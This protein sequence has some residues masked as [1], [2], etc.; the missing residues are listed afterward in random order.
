MSLYSIFDIAGS[1][2][3]AQNIRLNT[4]ASNLANADSVSS[5]QETTYRSRQPIF[6]QMMRDF[7]DKNNGVQVLG[8]VESNAPLRSEYNPNHAMA[9]KDGYIFRPNVNVID[10]MA[11]MISASRAYQT[12][13]EVLNTAKQMMMRTLSIGQ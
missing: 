12:N 9:N 10:E 6:A 11:N 13:V 2:M 3:N 8:V 1:A 5:T 4:T 7:G